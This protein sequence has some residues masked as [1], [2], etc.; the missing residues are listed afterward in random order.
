MDQKIRSGPNHQIATETARSISIKI[1]EL[2]IFNV[3]N[4]VE[5]KIW[6]AK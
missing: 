4:H 3:R 2:V 6:E 5:L 1:E